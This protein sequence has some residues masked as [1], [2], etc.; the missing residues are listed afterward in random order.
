MALSACG[1]SSTSNG[2]GNTGS[3][4]ISGGY[5]G[6]TTGGVAVGI[7]QVGG[8]YRQYWQPDGGRLCW[9]GCAEHF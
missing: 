7:L 3:T 5:G 1:S 2:A 4:A 8:V 6:A 9:G